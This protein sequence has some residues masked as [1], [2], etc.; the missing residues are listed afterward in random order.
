[1]IQS[2]STSIDSLFQKEES[3]Y[4][5]DLRVVGCLALELFLPQKFCALSDNV[6]FQRKLGFCRKLLQSEIAAPSSSLPTNVRN[7]VRS[8]LCSQL[9]VLSNLYL[10]S[11]IIELF[12]SNFFSLCLR[13]HH[14]AV[15]ACGLPPPTATRLLSNLT[16]PLGFPSSFEV[17]SETLR[18]FHQM[19]TMDFP[20]SAA[21]ELVPV[22]AEAKVKLL[23]SQILPILDQMTADEVVNNNEN[24]LDIFL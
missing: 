3:P 8:F 5:Q 21:G 19:E 16:S 23:A 17:L 14:P 12:P 22:I 13:D 15:S 10:C 6:D 7:F 2:F 20:T 11:S 24:I 9:D 4:L 1:M 18:C